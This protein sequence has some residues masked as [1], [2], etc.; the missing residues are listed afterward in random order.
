ENTMVAP[1]NP[2]P[3]FT[4]AADVV[5]FAH[6]QHGALH[7]LLIERVWDPFAGCWALPGGHVDPG[8]TFEQA[9]RREL[10]EETGLTAPARMVLVG[11]YDAV[12]RDPRGR[13][14]SVAY[15]GYAPRLLTP[16][17]ADDAVAAQWVPVD[18][19]STAALA[20]DHNLIVW[21]AVKAVA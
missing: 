13:V 14:I 18:D 12:G 10:T 11:V 7:V 6:D 3:S 15:A 8:E 5:L 1:E 20:F 4:L 16:T 17:A 21:D 9:A 2:I 19:L